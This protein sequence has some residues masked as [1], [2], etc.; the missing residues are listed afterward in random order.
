MM[1][2]WRGQKIYVAGWEPKA[3][4]FC[5][6]CGKQEN[7]LRPFGLHKQFVCVPCAKKNPEV[8]S[9][10]MSAAMA[11]ADLVVHFASVEL[12]KCNETKMRS[13]LDHWLLEGRAQA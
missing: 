4:E 8:A 12:S 2:E 11:G 1:I 9:T 7:S 3:P 10:L 13:L 5:Q 6:M